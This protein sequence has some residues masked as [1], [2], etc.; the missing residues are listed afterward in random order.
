MDPDTL[1]TFRCG[2]FL[3]ERIFEQAFARSFTHGDIVRPGEWKVDGIT[4]SPDYIETTRWRVVETKCTWKSVRKFNQL[5]KYFWVWLVQ[6]KGYC[7]MVGT[8][9]AILHAFFMNGDYKGSGPVI[10]SMEFTWTQQEIT[11][12]WEMLKGHARKKGWL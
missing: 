9:E 5:E 7:R 1:S 3:W 2:G 6:L 10:K 11:E 8:Q 12:N 4:G